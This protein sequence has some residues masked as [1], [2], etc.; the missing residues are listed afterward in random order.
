[1]GERFAQPGLLIAELGSG[2]RQVFPGRGGLCLVTAGQVVEG[3]QHGTRA[4]VTRKLAVPLGGSF[5]VPLRGSLRMHRSRLE[6][7]TGVN[8]N[9]RGA[10]SSICYIRQKNSA[11]LFAVSHCVISIST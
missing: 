7:N 6:G 11:T 3:V 5:Q 8:C 10:K 2:N 1:M 9:K 4:C